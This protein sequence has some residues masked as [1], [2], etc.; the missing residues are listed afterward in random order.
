[1]N[2]LATREEIGRY[3]KAWTDT[4]FIAVHEWNFKDGAF[5]QQI[6][7]NTNVIDG[8]DV[9]IASYELTK[10][11]KVVFSKAR[12]SMVKVMVDGLRMTSCEVTLEM[13]SF[14]E[15]VTDIFQGDSKDRGKYIPDVMAQSF[16]ANGNMA[17][18][19]EFTD[20]GVKVTAGGEVGVPPDAPESFKQKQREECIFNTGRKNPFTLTMVSLQVPRSGT[21]SPKLTLVTVLSK[22]P[23]TEKA[24]KAEYDDTFKKNLRGAFI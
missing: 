6:K 12:A 7:R 8:F 22:K 19:F 14:T 16:D 5:K 2:G 11:E 18:T 4:F 9:F 1:M 17:E 3:I 21:C 10:D 13:M 23:T 20:E 15:R 24:E